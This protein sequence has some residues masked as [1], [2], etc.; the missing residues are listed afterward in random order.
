MFSGNIPIES[1]MSSYLDMSDNGISGYDFCT[2]VK[3]LKTTETWISSRNLFWG[4]FKGF[5][6]QFL[7]IPKRGEKLFDGSILRIVG[8]D[9]KIVDLSSNDISGE[10]PKEIAN[11]DGLLNLNLSRNHFSDNIPRKIGA[12]HAISGVTWSLKNQAFWWNTS[13]FVKFDIL[14]LL[15]LLLQQSYCNNT[16]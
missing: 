14:E 9:M 10:I 4:F 7:D 16:I 6:Y 2:Y 1:C 15:G 13:K 11:L 8:L 12:M 3:I 5:C